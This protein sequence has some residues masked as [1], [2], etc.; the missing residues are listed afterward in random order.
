MKRENGRT[1]PRRLARA[2]LHIVGAFSAALCQAQSGPPAAT[3]GASPASQVP[4]SSR[5]TQPGSVITTQSTIS[6]GGGLDSLVIN[7]SI[8][9]QGAYTGSVPTGDNTKSV[10]PLRLDYALQLGLRYNLGALTEAQTVR[11]AEGI[12]QV[13]RSGLLP[14]ANTL[15]SET[16]EQVN[17]R[18]L[19]V[20]I[21]NFP[22]VVGPF[23][24]F[25]ARAA[26]VNQTVF[27]LVRLRNLRTAGENLKEAR[28]AAKD[29][30]DLVVLAVVGSYL[31]IIAGDARI[32]AARAQVQAAQSIYQQAVDRLR[33]GLNARIDTTRTEVQLKID[34]QRLRS[35]MA[36]RD[37]QKLKLARLIGLPLGQQFSIAD[38]FPYKPLNLTLS[39]T[40]DRAYRTR[41]DVQAAQAG[42]RA[43]DSALAAARAER[44][45]NLGLTADYGVSGLR[46]TASAHGVFDV[47]GTLTIPLY[48]GG[49]VRGDVEQAEAARRQRQAEL[50]DVRGQVDQDVRQAFIDLTAAADQIEVARSNVDLA[51][52]TL[53]QARDRL[54][55]GV[56][57]TVEVVQAEQAVV[58][59]HDDYIGA[60]FA[61][62]LGKASLA[63]AMGDAEENIQQF[64]LGK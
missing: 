44:L 58:Q 6:T 45:P 55:D 4:L 61:H 35:L 33:D 46:P 42:V 53:R 60:V 39:E 20:S 11:Q 54:A 27:D 56:A 26:R 49:R 21:P 38:D 24:F 10:L 63:R 62:N 18:T 19:G 43:A 47:V 5:A 25:D 22:A 7:S 9:I 48:Q 13:A 28:S 14:Q 34:Q 51:E 1:S 40:L 2:G 52:D 50:D 29:A 12:R 64:L 16:V 31:Q 17:L 3:P 23:N 8:N 36:D 37:S 30:R 59:A 32:D 57:D 15:V 41:A